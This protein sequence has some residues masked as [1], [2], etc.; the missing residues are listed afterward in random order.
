MQSRKITLIDEGGKQL[1]YVPLGRSG[2]VA[3]TIWKEDF[4]FLLKLGMSAN[5]SKIGTSYVACNSGKA[6][7]NK[8]QVAR[9]L[10]DAGSGE[11]IR[12]LDGNPFN[13]RRENLVVIASKRAFR[14]DRDLLPDVA[15]AA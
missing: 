10:M 13:L 5:W 8:L 7:G 6:K 2:T 12:Y 9:V 15:R 14:R 3:A 4:D 11:C 1:C